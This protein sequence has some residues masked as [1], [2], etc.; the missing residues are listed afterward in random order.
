M[1]VRACAPWSPECLVLPPLL[2]T[3]GHDEGQVND[4]ALRLVLRTGHAF[5]PTS[6]RAAGRQAMT[7][8]LVNSA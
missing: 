7:K 5:L 6:C 1:V 3:L 2:E 4:S 8:Q